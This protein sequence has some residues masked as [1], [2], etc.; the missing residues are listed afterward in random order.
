[1]IEMHD[2]VPGSQLVERGDERADP[3]GRRRSRRGPRPEELRRGQRQEAGS[4]VEKTGGE[5]AVNERERPGVSAEIAGPDDL[6]RY[7]GLAEE[8]PHALRLAERLRGDEHRPHCGDGS[9]ARSKD[10]KV[11][12]GAPSLPRRQPEA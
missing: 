7:P 11:L 8:V 12:S 5:P 1:V 10:G 9:Q 4:G 6:D 3:S 2:V